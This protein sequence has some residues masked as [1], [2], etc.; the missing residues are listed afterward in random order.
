M[1]HNSGPTLHEFWSDVRL[2]PDVEWIVVDNNSTDDTVAIAESLGAKVVEQS[3]NRGFGVAN[4]VGFDVS[5]GDFICFVNPDVRVDVAGLNLLE[6]TIRDQGVLVAPQL[7]NMDGSL[8]PNGRSW[9]F[10][11]HKILHRLNPQ[12]VSGVYTFENSDEMN[13]QVIWVIGAVVASSRD[14]FLRL[15]PWDKSFLF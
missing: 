9:P 11:A 3:R 15:G 1:T 8:Q 13:A 12:R 7:L 4:N 14:I 2:P 6:K 5:S 10:L